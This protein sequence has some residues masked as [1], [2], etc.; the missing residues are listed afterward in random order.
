MFPRS[1][2]QDIL[3]LTFDVDDAPNEFRAQFPLIHVTCVEHTGVGAFLYLSAQEQVNV[4]EP[5]HPNAWEGPEIK[6]P[7]LDVH[8]E[9]VVHL[10]HGRIDHIE[11]WSVS[12]DFPKGP[13]ETYRLQQTWQGSSGEWVELNGGKRSSSRPSSI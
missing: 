13:I 7:G 10:H 12:G 1:F 11:L 2:V 6:C 3:S 4:L 5:D 8:A 9:C